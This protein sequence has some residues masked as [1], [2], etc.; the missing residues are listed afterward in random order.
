MTMVQLLANKFQRFTVKSK[1]VYWCG[2]EDKGL[3]NL[4]RVTFV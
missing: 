4:A 2:D 1:N 3:G